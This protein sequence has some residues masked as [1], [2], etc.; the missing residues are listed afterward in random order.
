MISIIKY[1][2]EADPDMAL[3]IG[4]FLSGKVADKP[5]AGAVV[6][7][8]HTTTVPANDPSDNAVLNAAKKTKVGSIFGKRVPEGL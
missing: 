1:L 4:R 3:R 6:N 8:I 7:A 2:S 5:S